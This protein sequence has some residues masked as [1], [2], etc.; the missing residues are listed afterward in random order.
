M[1]QAVSIWTDAA[2]AFPPTKKPP[3]GGR[4]AGAENL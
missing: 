1:K 3:E 2:M 4:F